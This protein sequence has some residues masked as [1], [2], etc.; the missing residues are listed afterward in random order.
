VLS[1][2]QAIPAGLILNEIISN[3]LKHAFPG[4]RAGS[5]VIEGERSG[6]NVALSVHDDG[7]GIPADYEARSAKSLGLQIVKI[8][9]RQLRGELSIES[10]TGTTFRVT[11][12]ERKD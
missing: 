4:G 2:G 8:L 12:P 3:A 5:L 1:V 6:G 9:T 7:V 10:G 11:F